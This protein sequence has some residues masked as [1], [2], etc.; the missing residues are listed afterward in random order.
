MGLPRKTWRRIIEGNIKKMGKT[1]K[2][3]EKIAMDGHKWR[4][5]V[6]ALCATGHQEDM[7]VGSGFSTGSHTK[8]IYS[9]IKNHKSFR[10]QYIKEQLCL[11]SLN[12]LKLL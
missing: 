3:V 4:D 9:W 12:D 11:F 7:Q 5:L 8:C 1:W 10:A 6:P 2:E